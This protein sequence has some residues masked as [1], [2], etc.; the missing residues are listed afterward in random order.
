M[1]EQPRCDSAEQG[2]TAAC[3]DKQRAGTRMSRFVAA[4]IFLIVFF[5]H[6]LQIN[7][8]LAKWPSFVLH[9][10]KTNICSE[11]FLES[12]LEKKSLCFGNSPNWEGVSWRIRRCRHTRTGRSLPLPF[13]AA[14]WTIR[15][16]DKS[17][18]GTSVFYRYKHC[19]GRRQIK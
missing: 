18:V 13:R 6:F 1:E 8:V 11:L 15:L 14:L 4:H 3:Q 5:W 17:A 10:H 7:L 19:R 16:K 2:W 12:R 9:V